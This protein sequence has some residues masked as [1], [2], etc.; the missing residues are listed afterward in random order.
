[1][2]GMPCKH[3][4]LLGRG[5]NPNANCCANFGS[6]A[7]MHAQP[8]RA[9]VFLARITASAPADLRAPGPSGPMPPTGALPPPDTRGR[10]AAVVARSAGEPHLDQG[11]GRS[12]VEQ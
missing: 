3:D 12:P 6:H 1:M 2:T 7:S 11:A 9:T 4:T 8:Q 5:R 10:A